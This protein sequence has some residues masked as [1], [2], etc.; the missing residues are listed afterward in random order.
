[1]LKLIAIIE[2][3]SILGL[4]PTGVEHLPG[5]LVANNGTAV[6]SLGTILRTTDGGQNW[7]REESG[8][9]HILYGVSFADPSTGNVVGEFG[10]ILRTANQGPAPTP[11]ATPSPTPSAT[12]RVT[13]RPRPT[14]P[15]RPIP[16][17]PAPSF[18]SGLEA[19]ASGAI[20]L[21]EGNVIN[22]KIYDT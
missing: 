1:M 19:K 9:N 5:S 14:P 16:P 12:P 20:D 7:T 11:T 22:G 8:T 2:A 18:N 15:P 13:Q 6:G 21:Y 10:T 17:G 3:P 4:R